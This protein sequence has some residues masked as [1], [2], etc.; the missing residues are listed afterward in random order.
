MT[1]SYDIFNDFG[2]KK[3]ILVILS[4]SWYVTHG[5][6]AGLFSNVYSLWIIGTVT[7]TKTLMEKWLEP[8]LSFSVPVH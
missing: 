4:I 2:T 6:I 5:Q 7:I 1:H 3:I 8:D